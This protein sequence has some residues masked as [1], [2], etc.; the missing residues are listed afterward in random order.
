MAKPEVTVAAAIL[1]EG[2][3]VLIARRSDGGEHDGLWELPGGK[4]EP[5]ESVE[6]CLVREIAEEL[7]TTITVD[8]RFGEYIHEYRERTIRLVCCSCAA[9]SPLDRLAPAP[10][11]HSDLAL[12]PRERLLEYRYTAADVP[13]I[14]ALTSGGSG[15]NQ[16]A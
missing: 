4:V 1:C 5:G 16:L 2:D 12:V 9:D 14:E 13:V 7:G 6:A 3:R 8:S 10:G 11:I 15:K